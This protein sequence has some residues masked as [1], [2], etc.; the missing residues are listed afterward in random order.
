MTDVE[1]TQAQI[2]DFLKAAR[3]L[4]RLGKAGLYIYLDENDLN[5]LTGPSHEGPG[6]ARQDRV[7]ASHLIP[8][9]GGG[10]W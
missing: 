5:L 8:L 10:G 3:I 1:P 9:A 6:H 4:A 2:R 7:R